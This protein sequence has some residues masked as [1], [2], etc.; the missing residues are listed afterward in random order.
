M[1]ESLYRWLFIPRNKRRRTQWSPV[2]CKE[3]SYEVQEVSPTL[4][5][6]EVWTHP[7][8]R[9]SAWILAK[10]LAPNVQ[11]A[12]WDAEEALAEILALGP[13]KLA[14]PETSK[15][16]DPR[17]GVWVERERGWRL[18][19][20]HFVAATDAQRYWELNARSVELAAL[21]MESEGRPPYLET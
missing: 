1:F 16:E 19:G 3:A 5:T 10:G 4:A 15:K 7:P 13:K 17:F 8:G 18:P 21:T 2:A 14:A 11:Q 20:G 12:T 9:A 6:W